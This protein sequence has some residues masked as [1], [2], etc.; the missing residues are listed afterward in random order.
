M[1]FH[2]SDRTCLLQPK[3]IIYPFTEYLSND[4]KQCD[5]TSYRTC[6]IFV[7]DQSFKNNLTGK[8]YKTISYDRL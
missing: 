4:S 2:L 3:I 1:L 5:E 7:N 6:N 8:E